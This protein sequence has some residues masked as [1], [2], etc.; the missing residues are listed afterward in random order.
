MRRSKAL[1]DAEDIGEQAQRQARI[2]G[3][4]VFEE[5]VNERVGL[6]EFEREEQIAFGGG[7]VRINKG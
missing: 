1:P 4:L 7:E 5:Q 2:L 6:G 3:A